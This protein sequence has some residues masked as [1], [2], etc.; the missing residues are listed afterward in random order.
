MQPYHHKK[1]SNASIKVIMIFSYEPEQNLA[2]LW[3]WSAHCREPLE[4]QWKGIRKQY[5]QTAS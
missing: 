2:V 4:E 1:L 5:Y 3:S